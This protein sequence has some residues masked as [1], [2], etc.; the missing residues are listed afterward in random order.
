MNGRKK[1]K[2][3][4]PEE[5]HENVPPDWYFRSIKENIFQR[6]WHKR[7]FNEIGKLV[8]EIDGNIL[9]LGSA[10][11]V[12]SKVIFDKSKARKLVG[13]DVLTSSVAW[14][15]RH[16]K[17][18]GM[19]FVV[20]DAERLVFPAGSFAAVFALEVLEHVKN[21]EKVLKEIKRVLRP[22]GYGIFLVPTDSI[23]FRSIW[24]FWTKFRGKVW[25]DTHIQ[26]YR[27][28]YLPKLC[29]KA[30]F[31]IDANKKFILGMLQAVKVRK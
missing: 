31:K 26:T 9:D 17:G 6:C 10:D 19:K 18:S 16:W 22:G 3:K 28:N 21:P 24:L 30:G 15:N 29:K 7:R 25:K 14:A 2:I 8:E 5:L 1:G 4:S 23:L 27:N 13:L 12:F 20:G 11:G